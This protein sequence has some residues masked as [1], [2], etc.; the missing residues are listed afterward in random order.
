M[1]LHRLVEEFAGRS[2][3]CTTAHELFTITEAAAREIGFPRIALVHG[4]WFR[5]P[6]RRL[7]RLDNFGEWADIFIERKY[8]LDDPA[9]LA[10]Q[11]T[12]TAFPWTELSELIPFGRNQLTILSEAQSHGL[13]TGFT[14]PVGVMGEPHGCCSFSSDK[15]ELPSRWHRRAATLIAADAF[16]EAR[17]LHGFPARARRVP[18]LSKRKL[19]CLRLLAIGKTDGEI[20]TILGLK[21]PTVR[22]Y[23]TSLRKDFDVVSRAQLTADALR[24][25]FVG[26]DD[27]IPAS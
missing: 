21:K 1:G 4:L 9:L 17:R 5:Q 22:T 23:M 6:D 27:A 16:R 8:Y 14:L 25:G 2:R 26:F 11:R 3:R 7:I 10:C 15:P 20:A 12:N 24:F 13:Q 19:E 18:R